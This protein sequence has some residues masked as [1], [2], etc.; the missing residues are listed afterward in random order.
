MSCPSSRRGCDSGGPHLAV[1]MAGRS[2]ALCSVCVACVAAVAARAAA[3]GQISAARGAVAAARTGVGRRGP[4]E[5]A[6]PTWPSTVCAAK[7]GACMEAAGGAVDAPRVGAAV[8]GASQRQRGALVGEGGACGLRAAT[9]SNGALISRR[10]RSREVPAATVATPSRPARRR[11]TAH[12][13]CNHPVALSSA[14]E[15]KVQTTPF[16]VGVARRPSAFRRSDGAI[17]VGARRRAR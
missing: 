2:R 8:V 17:G 1:G 6:V 3:G 12:A 10:T 16:R 15:R 11:R 14:H 4:V 13:T 7:D 5:A 9:V